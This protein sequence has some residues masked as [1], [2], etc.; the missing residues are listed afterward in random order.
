MTASPTQQHLDNAFAERAIQTIQKIAWSLL[1]DANLA[2]RWWLYAVSQAA[3][4]HNRLA[5]TTHGHITPF[6]LFHQE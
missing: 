5:G 6:E 3:F 1:Y 2:E 4:I